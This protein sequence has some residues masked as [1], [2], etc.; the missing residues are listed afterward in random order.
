MHSTG[1]YAHEQLDTE[2][3]NLIALDLDHVA[4]DANKGLVTGEDYYR[5]LLSVLPISPV[6]YPGAMESMKAS[7]FNITIFPNVE[8]TLKTLKERHGVKLGVI[9]DSMASTA[10]KKAWMKQAG[11]D[12]DIFD[13]IVNSSEVGT[14]KPDARMYERALH[15]LGVSAQDA[16]F[17]GHKKTELDGAKSVGCSTLVMFPDHDLLTQGG[18]PM[19]QYD[20]FVPGWKHI[21]EVPMWGPPETRL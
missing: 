18:L 8:S 4:K 12:V 20:F 5:M 19:T 9:T 17:V 13:V 1:R 14:T 21:L 15:T 16:V 3:L 2:T 7:S 6:D 10:E 11:L